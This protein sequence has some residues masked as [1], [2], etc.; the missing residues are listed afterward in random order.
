MVMSETLLEKTKRMIE[1][2]KDGKFVEGMEEFYADDVI[3]EEPTGVKTAGKPTLIENEK[4]T[5]ENVAAYHGIEISS[6]G[7][8]EDDGQGSG[9]TFAEYKL[10]VDMKDG[11]KFNPDQV[12][13]TRWE[14]GKA[15]RIKFY[16]NPNL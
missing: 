8:G 7:V 5:L 3:N 1:G 16:Y 2:L 13:V 15:K 11:S 10:S 9:V 14:N 12:Q 6:F 4:E